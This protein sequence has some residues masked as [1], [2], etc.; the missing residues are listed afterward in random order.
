MRMYDISSRRSDM[1]RHVSVTANHPRSY[2]Y[3]SGVYARFKRE[4]Q[5]LQANLWHMH[6]LC[7]SRKRRIV[8]RIKENAA[9]LLLCGAELAQEQLPQEDGDLHHHN[10]RHVV[11]GLHANQ[12]VSVEV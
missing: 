9:Y 8:Q 3:C 4:I 2:T 11:H 12:G 7:P 1:A 5:A 6:T 10:H